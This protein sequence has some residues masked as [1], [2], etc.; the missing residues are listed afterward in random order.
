MDV[1]ACTPHPGFGSVLLRNGAQRRIV[2]LAT[3]RSRALGPGTTV[4]LRGDTRAIRVGGRT[5]VAAPRGS[6]LAALGSSPDRKWVLFAVDPMASVSVAADGL[7]VQA[8]S[9]RT[10]RVRTIAT[11]LVYGDYRA[12]CGNRLVM[13][14]GGDRMSTHHKWLLVASPP[15]WRVRVLVRDP[16]RAFGALACDGDSVVVQSARDS[17]DDYTKAGQWSLW[18]V[19]LATGAL[20]R[21]TAPPPGSDDDSPRV[22]PGGKVM[23]VR[24]RAHVGTLYGLG[25]GPLLRVGRDPD[26]Y[27]GHRGWPNVSPVARR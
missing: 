22:T 24:T 26:E 21:L 16:R 10:K 6:D 25:A 11:G 19:S 5:L 17:G 15:A 27:Y 7:K 9:V 18:R 14:A 1:V 12:W 8:V 3:C 4:A 2:D 20:H 13:T 23:F